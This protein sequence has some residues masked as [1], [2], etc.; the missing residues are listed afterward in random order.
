MCDMEPILPDDCRK[1]F[2]YENNTTN[3]ISTSILWRSWCTEGRYSIHIAVVLNRCAM[4][5][6]R[7]PS[8]N[9]RGSLEHGDQDTHSIRTYDLWGRA[10]LRYH[11]MQ[12]AANLAQ[13]LLGMT[14]MVVRFVQCSPWIH[15]GCQC[16]MI[17]LARS[18]ILCTTVKLLETDATNK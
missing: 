13:S 6:I 10:R 18:L 1:R 12:G 2:M 9:L 7:G 3:F 5:P 11:W 4:E 15:C 17:M 16:G 14:V 8:A